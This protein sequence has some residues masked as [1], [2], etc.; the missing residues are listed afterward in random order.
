[1]VVDHL[2]SGHQDPLSDVHH[3]MFVEVETDPEIENLGA[4]GSSGAKTRERERER[5]QL[6]EGVN[7]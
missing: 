7:I 5:E 3:A 6:R 1:V 2:E 4:H